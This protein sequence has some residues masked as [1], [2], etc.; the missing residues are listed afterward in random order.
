[1]FDKKGRTGNKAFT[2]TERG[3]CKYC[4]N[5]NPWIITHKE[6]T[7]TRMKFRLTV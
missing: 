6:N 7:H 4:E 1:M 5:C 2:E 3:E